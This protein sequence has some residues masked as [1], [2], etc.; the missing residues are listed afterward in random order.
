MAVRK[1]GERPF[2]I[3]DA[4]VLI[5]ALAAGFAWTAAAW[6]QFQPGEFY[7]PHPWGRAW[8]TIILANVGVLP[9]LLALTVGTFVVRV[10]QPRPPWRWVARQPGTTACLGVLIC[11]ASTVPLMAVWSMGQIRRNPGLQIEF[12]EQ[13]AIT[14]LEVMSTMAAPLGIFVF[15]T[16]LLLAIQRG[17]R[18]E[19]TWIDR[20]GRFVGTA[21]IVVGGI[22]GAE[23]MRIYAI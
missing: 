8:Q 13:T 12:H 2:T 11:L 19:R 6:K 16:W 4:M 20:L 21:W 9:C 22:I 7:S 5:A 14:L 23:F 1:R 17:W 10:R 15:M 18:G 3:G